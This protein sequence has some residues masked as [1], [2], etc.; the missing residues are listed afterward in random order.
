MHGASRAP[1]AIAE[2]AIHDCISPLD[3]RKALVPAPTGVSPAPPSS[4]NT[5]RTTIKRVSMWI[6]SGQR[7]LVDSSAKESPDL[8]GRCHV[9]KDEG[10][11][12]FTS[13]H[14]H[15]LCVF[16]LGGKLL[17][18]AGSEDLLLTRGATRKLTSRAGQ[19]LGGNR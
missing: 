10:R 16:F 17:V 13:R 7:K 15:V 5:T 2:L 8:H 4:K 6:L 1:P 18:L 14:F 19:R 12:L 3:V 11:Y 9:K